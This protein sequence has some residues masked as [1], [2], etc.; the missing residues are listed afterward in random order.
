MTQIFKKKIG[1]SLPFLAAGTTDTKFLGSTGVATANST[2]KYQKYKSVELGDQLV[3]GGQ[4]C[5]LQV[6][7]WIRCA[8]GN[9]LF[10]GCICLFF[11]WLPTPVGALPHISSSAGGGRASDHI[12]PL[13]GLPISP[14]YW[15]PPTRP[16]QMSPLL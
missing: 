12:S 16:I 4:I 1:P 6:N 8:S 9:V 2:N 7:F 15:L 14:A 13:A 10:V 3:T 5:K 11:W